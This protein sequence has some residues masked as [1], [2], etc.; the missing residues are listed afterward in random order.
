MLCITSADDINI[1][2]S[3]SDLDALYF[4]LPTMPFHRKFLTIINDIDG[5]YN[6]LHF[7]AIDAEQ[8]KSQCKRFDIKSVPTVMIMRHGREID[9][10]VGLVRTNVFKSAICGYI[11]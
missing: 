1:H 7:Y 2:T 5:K 9:R 4:Y 11:H 3:S 8:F 6:N 10:I